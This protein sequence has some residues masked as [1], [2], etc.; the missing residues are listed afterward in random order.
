MEDFNQINFKSLR[1]FVAV[2]AQGSFSEVARREAISPSTISR[3]IKLMEQAL[4]TQLLYRNTR[5]VSP[6]E[7]GKLLGHHARQY[8]VHLAQFVDVTVL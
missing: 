6:T 3:A 5:T 8:P 1:L 7:S 2:L 4:K